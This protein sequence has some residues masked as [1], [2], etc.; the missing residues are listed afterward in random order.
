MPNGLK[1]QFNLNDSILRGP[2]GEVIVIGLRNSNLYEINFIKV[3]G[4]GCGRFGT[5]MEER[6][7]T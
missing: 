1:V 7:C 2:H 3:Y 5:T 4:G 6:W